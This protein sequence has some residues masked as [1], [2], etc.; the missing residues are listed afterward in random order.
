[1]KTSL[2]KFNGKVIKINGQVKIFSY[3]NDRPNLFDDIVTIANA[4]KF[5]IY[6]EK[7][8][9]SFLEEVTVSN[10]YAFAIRKIRLSKDNKEVYTGTSIDMNG[11]VYGYVF[12]SFEGAYY[13]IP[14]DNDNYEDTLINIKDSIDKNRAREKSYILL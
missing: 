14:V 11:V 1:M 12:S 10:N 3:E 4:D 8:L 5:Y 9:A 13:S 2:S 6:F 7:D